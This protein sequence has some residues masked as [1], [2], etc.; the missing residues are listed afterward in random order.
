MEQLQNLIEEIVLELLP[1][2]LEAVIKRFWLFG[3]KLQHL[4]SCGSHL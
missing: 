1:C 2:L 4:T 3:V